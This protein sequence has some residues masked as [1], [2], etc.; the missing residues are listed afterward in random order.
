MAHQE[1]KDLLNKLSYCQTTCE[2]CADACLSEDNVAE[3]AECIRLDRDCA[4]ICDLALK[5]ISRDSKRAS[6]VVELCA[7]ICDECAAEC[8]K[9]DKGHCK[10]CAEA[11]R[12]CAE[13][14]RN[15]FASAV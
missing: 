7:E 4:D 14:C 11:C 9:H 10:D 6:S 13:V 8:E 15:T 3:M 12:E 1:N 2:H 5:Y